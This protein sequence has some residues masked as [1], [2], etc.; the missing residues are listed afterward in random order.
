MSL[1]RMFKYSTYS[2]KLSLA[3]SLGQSET[4][5]HVRNR[6]QDV[7]AMMANASMIT[8]MVVICWLVVIFDGS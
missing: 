4:N 2:P 7:Q 5:L 3:D 8:K 1:I 6:K